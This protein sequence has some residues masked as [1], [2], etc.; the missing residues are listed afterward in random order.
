MK[1]H[2]RHPVFCYILRKVLRQIVRAHALSQFIE[3][4]KNRKMQCDISIRKAFGLPRLI[5]WVLTGHAAIY[6]QENVLSIRRLR[7]P[8]VA[9]FTRVCDTSAVILFALLIIL[10]VSLLAIVP[11]KCKAIYRILVFGTKSDHPHGDNVCA[12]VDCA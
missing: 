1:P 10:F 8:H 12:A 6:R 3:N 5:E 7:E 9:V 11:S 2:L 4:I